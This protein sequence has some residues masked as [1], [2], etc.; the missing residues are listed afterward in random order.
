MMGAFCVL[1]P[2]PPRVGVGN[3]EV[4]PYTRGQQADFVP[5]RLEAASERVPLQLLLDPHCNW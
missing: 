3:L 2:S 1:W 4:A 5:V